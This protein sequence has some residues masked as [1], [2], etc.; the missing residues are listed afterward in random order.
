MS[1]KLTNDEDRVERLKY[2]IERLNYIKSTPTTP[3]G[4]DRLDDILYGGIPTGY[5]ILLTSPPLD[6]KDRI[7]ESFLQ[8]GLDN[9]ETALLLTTMM[10][11]VI[12]RFV[13]NYR[14]TFYLMLC[15][16]WVDESI[17]D[18]PNV[19][20][21]YGVEDLTQLNISL[22]V[23]LRE[24]NEKGYKINR[25]VIELLSDV[26]LMH[27]TRVVRRWLMDLITLFKQQK[28]TTLA[29]L[30]QGMHT[31]SEAR[32]IIDLFDG[33][34]DIM[35]KKSANGTETKIKIKRLYNKKYQKNELE[36]RV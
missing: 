4:I 6:E 2:V 26:L 16:P 25:V 34:M 12:N 32:V 11:R 33:H 13:I 24:I 14:D 7:T 5:S 3:T 8:Q 19:C 22:K 27:E 29:N 36:L 15:S 17:Q 35:E 20:T 31:P 30:D 21:F 23:F 10:K 28:I 1:Q 18:M 9:D